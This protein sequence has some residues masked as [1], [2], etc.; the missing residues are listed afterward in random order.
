MKVWIILTILLSV[1]CAS[2]GHG[3]Y[4]QVAI[5][6]NPSGANVSVD[7]GKGTQSA[8][9]TPATVNLKRNADPCKVNLSKEGYEDSSVVFAKAVSGW[10]WGNLFFGGIPGW[11]IDAADGAMYNRVPDSALVTLVKKGT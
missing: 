10:V 7:C 4:Q 6:S 11:I 5:N 9:Q 2:I 1:G 8:G 3:R